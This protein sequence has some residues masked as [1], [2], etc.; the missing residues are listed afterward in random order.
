MAIG[1]NDLIFKTALIELPLN[2][3]FSTLLIFPFGMEGVAWGTVIAFLSEKVILAYRLRRISGL[4]LKDFQPIQLWL[5]YSAL[6][7]AA[8]I[9]SEIFVYQ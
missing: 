8:Y 5:L 3:L 7:L 2:I 1:R 9:I 4:R 6:M